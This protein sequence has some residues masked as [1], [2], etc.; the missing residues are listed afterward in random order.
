MSNEFLS[1]VR[2]YRRVATVSP[3]LLQELPNASTGLNV[4]QTRP[5]VRVTNLADTEERYI[6]GLAD[7]D[8]F[9]VECMTDKI[10]SPNIQDLFIS[11]F[12]TT[13]TLEIW[14]TDKNVSPNTITKYR[15]DAIF[16]Q[17]QRNP[18]VGEADRITFNFKIS[19]AVTDVS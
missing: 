9:P 18:G 4:G 14:F 1:N 8:E 10:S 5:L 17:W 13:Q 11:L 7:G 12:G 19:G 6:A 16:L 3:I 2:L 15:F